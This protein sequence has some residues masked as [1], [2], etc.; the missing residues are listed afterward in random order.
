M[1]RGIRPR[2]AAPI[3]PEAP[4]STTLAAHDQIYGLPTCADNQTHGATAVGNRQTHGS[5]RALESQ[6]PT[7]LACS[8]EN[9]THG[10]AK[11]TGPSNPRV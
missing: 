8:E 9:E 7:G 4:G 1:G 11:H 3:A 5:T 6:T 10:S 2:G